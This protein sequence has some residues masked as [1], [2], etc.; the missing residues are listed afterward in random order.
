VYHSVDF[1]GTGHQEMLTD[2]VIFLWSA[3]GFI[4]FEEW[5]AYRSQDSEK[6]YRRVS[7]WIKR[8]LMCGIAGLVALA[9]IRFVNSAES[10][11]RLLAM[12]IGFSAPS[13]PNLMAQV[14]RSMLIFAS[15]HADQRTDSSN[16]NIAQ[17]FDPPYDAGGSQ[18]PP[19]PPADEDKAT[20]KREDQTVGHR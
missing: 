13:L 15:G 18:K 9:I 7:F 12:A 17:I 6:R 19:I 20:E 16:V 5:T 3:S 8:V 10:K 2:I 11:A 4:A 1:L 14:L